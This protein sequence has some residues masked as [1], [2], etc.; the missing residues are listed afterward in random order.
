MAYD[1]NQMLGNPWLNFGMGM[2][3]ASAPSTNPQSGSMAYALSKGLGSLQKGNTAAIETQRSQEYARMMQEAIKAKQAR[4]EKGKKNNLSSMIN[5]E[6]WTMLMQNPQFRAEMQRMLGG[7]PLTS[8]TPGY[9]S[10]LY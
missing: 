3:E 10:G 2:L 8:N 1:P 6:L 4:E 7:D 5:P 9:L